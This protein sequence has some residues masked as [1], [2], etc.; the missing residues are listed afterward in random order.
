MVMA[1]IKKRK[2]KGAIV[3]NPSILAYPKSMMFDSN[4]NTHRNKPFTIRKTAI[5]T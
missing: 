2:T 4:G 5:T 3:N 1:G